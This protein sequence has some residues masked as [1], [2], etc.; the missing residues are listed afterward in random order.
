MLS[1]KL[2]A[3]CREMW[4]L[5]KGEVSVSVMSSPERDRKAKLLAK[6][7]KIFPLVTPH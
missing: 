2:S 1:L 6:A 7:C 3:Q 5:G 4:S